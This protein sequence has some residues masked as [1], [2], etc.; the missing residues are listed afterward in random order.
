MSSVG[1][2]DGSSCPTYFSQSD[3]LT[4]LIIETAFTNRSLFAYFCS[5]VS[6]LIFGTLT[7]DDLLLPL[8]PLASIINVFPVLQF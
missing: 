4:E 5:L 3:D 2:T 7:F 8:D 1:A 6:G